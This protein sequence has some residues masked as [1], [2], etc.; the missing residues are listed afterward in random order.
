MDNW[1]YTCVG[2]GEKNDVECINCGRKLFKGFK[3]GDVRW[4]ECVHCKY[5]N[6]E[7]L[8]VCDFTPRGT[9]WDGVPTPQIIH[10]QATTSINANRDFFYKVVYEENLNQSK[11]NDSFLTNTFLPIIVFVLFLGIIMVSLSQ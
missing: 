4:L 8:H 6:D 1:I 2:C 5:E 10:K 3:K 11:R 7:M 9:N